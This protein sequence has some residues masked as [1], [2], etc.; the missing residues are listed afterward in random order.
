MSAASLLRRLAPPALIAAAA[1]AAIAHPPGR[2]PAP[3]EDAPCP[4]DATALLGGLSVGDDLGGWRVAAT[5]APRER[6]LAVDVARAGVAATV[7]IVRRG[8]RQGEPPRSTARYDLFYRN[9]PAVT[10][11]ALVPALDALARR[12]AAHEAGPV[13]DGL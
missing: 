3:P 11:E 5:H 10:C 13:P 12:V 1:L 2:H 8:A 7:E 6:A 9:A 4:A